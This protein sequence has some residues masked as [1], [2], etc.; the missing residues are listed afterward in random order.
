M[1]CNQNWCNVCL[2]NERMSLNECD[3]WQA[4]ISIKIIGVR[5][6]EMNH[7]WLNGWY[8]GYHVASYLSLKKLTVFREISILRDKS[9]LHNYPLA[10]NSTDENRA[11]ESN[12]SRVTSV[13]YI[14]PNKVHET[15]L[16]PPLPHALLLTASWWLIL[17]QHS[18][19]KR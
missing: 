2:I 6:S 7:D 11:R 19:N 9:I 18:A 4:S 14:Y 8:I 16:G 17:L 1:Q 10:C 13:Q 15:K 3:Q 12:H 5:V